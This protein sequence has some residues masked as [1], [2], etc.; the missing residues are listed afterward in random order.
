V[1]A[2]DLRNYVGD[3]RQRRLQRAAAIGDRGN[4]AA[5]EFICATLRG[6]G[7]IAGRR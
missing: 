3:A 4:R 5:E 7:V 6:S 2:D 1:S